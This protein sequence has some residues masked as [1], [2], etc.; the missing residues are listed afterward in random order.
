MVSEGKLALK[1]LAFVK[2]GSA[3]TYDNN[4]D[5]KK[6]SLHESFQRNGHQLLL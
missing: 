2:I 3:S 6:L 5:R 1:C 4:S